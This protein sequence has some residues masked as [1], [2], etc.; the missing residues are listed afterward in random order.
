MTPDLKQRT[1]QTLDWMITDMKFRADDLRNN[2]EEGSAG[3]YSDELTKA[4]NL[5]AELENE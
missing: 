5:L 3:G 2:V 1:I 4:I